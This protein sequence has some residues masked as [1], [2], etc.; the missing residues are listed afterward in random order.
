ME[1]G[2]GPVHL[3]LYDS[4]PSSILGLKIDSDIT[5]PDKCAYFNEKLI[6]S[7]KVLLVKMLV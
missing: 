3:D 6:I 5:M 1:I 7:S 4:K 2:S